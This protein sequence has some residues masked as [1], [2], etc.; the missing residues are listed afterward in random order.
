M[1]HIIRLK[2]GNN[3]FYFER[4]FSAVGKLETYCTV[5]IDSQY[6]EKVEIIKKRSKFHIKFLFY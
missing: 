4:T 6:G 5:I 1:N 3:V 2:K